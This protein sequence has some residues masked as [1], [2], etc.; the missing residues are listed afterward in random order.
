M[1]SASIV[2]LLI[3]KFK[4]RKKEVNY[5]NIY[6]LSEEFRN[7]KKKKIKKTHFFKVI[8][9]CIHVYNL[10]CLDILLWNILHNW[11]TFLQVKLIVYIQ[12]SLNTIN[13]RNSNNF[14]YIYTSLVNEYKDILNRCDNSSYRCT[15]HLRCMSP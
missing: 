14:Y 4:E 8:C 5:R 10:A 6:E 2:K 1:K 15:K 11:N 12:S 9:F 13:N 7:L 3:T